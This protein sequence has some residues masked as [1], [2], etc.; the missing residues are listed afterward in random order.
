MAEGRVMRAEKATTDLEAEIRGMRQQI[1]V[2]QQTLE[3][4]QVT[5]PACIFF[6]FRA[7]D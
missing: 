6:S 5:C 7:H 3:V 4:Q 1:D 2:Q